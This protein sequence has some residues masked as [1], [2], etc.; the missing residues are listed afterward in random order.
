MRRFVFAALFFATTAF[1]R[2]DHI[3]VT[4]R[5]DYLGG[6]SFGLAGAYERIQGRAYFAL[7][8]ANAHDR[9]IVDLDRA[10]RNAKGEVEFSADVDILVPKKGGNGTLFIN[11]G[12]SLVGRRATCTP[13]LAMARGFESKA[14]ESNRQDAEDERAARGKRRPDVHEIETRQKREGLELSRRRILH[15]METANEGR[16]A[17]LQ[18]A[19]AHLDGELAKIQ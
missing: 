6:K 17:S 18:A 10:P 15:E 5:A 13:I 19:L 12:G 1:A 3:E 8:P 11:A 7:D 2:V 14:V 16:R 9:V 4:S